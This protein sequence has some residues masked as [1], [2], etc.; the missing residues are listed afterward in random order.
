MVN[1]QSISSI[2]SD[3][4]VGL[5]NYQG[6]PNNLAM[7]EV[8]IAVPNRLNLNF[9]NSAFLPFNDLTLFQVGLEMDRRTSSNSRGTTQEVTAGLRYLNFSFPILTN[10]WTSSFGITPYSSVNYKSFTVDSLDNNQTVVS[11][12]FSGSGGLTSLRWANGFRISKELYLGVRSSYVFGTIENDAIS[13]I[14]DN[15][16]ANNAIEFNDRSSYKGVTLELSAGYRKELG[17]ERALNF[18]VVYE[19]K[20][21]LKGKSNQTFASLGGGLRTLTERTVNENVPISFTLPSSIGLGVAYQLNNTFLIGMDLKSTNWK[22]AGADGDAFE[23]T[24]KIGIGGQ[25]TPDFN[26]VNQ[27]LKRITY[28]MGVSFGNLPY[29][30]NGQTIQE[31]GINFGLSLPVGAS[32]LDLAFKYGGLGS[33]QDDLI[34]ETY[35]RLVIGATINDRWFIKRRYN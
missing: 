10:K 22:N 13:V 6:L 5:L 33:T 11:T 31:F 8:G 26:S 29:T 30:I 18:G 2:Y 7:G 14:E 15:Q 21:D 3:R 25:W 19:L 27:Y 23:N 4:G 12:Q 20:K 35:F 17:D 1:G 16:V 32:N 9:Q 24:T 34:R 28:R